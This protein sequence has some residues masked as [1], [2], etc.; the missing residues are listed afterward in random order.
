MIR[1][2]VHNE[3][4]WY[5]SHSSPS[6][7]ALRLPLPPSASKVWLVTAVSVLNGWGPYRRV[8]NYDVMIMKMLLYDSLFGNIWFKCNLRI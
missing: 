3:E 8:D 1:N 4:T 7:T 2:I 6:F 5:Y